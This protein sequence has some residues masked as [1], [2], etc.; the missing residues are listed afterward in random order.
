MDPFLIKIQRGDIRDARVRER[1]SLE[2]D[3]DVVVADSFRKHPRHH[4]AKFQNSS[5]LFYLC[6]LLFTGLFS[7]LYYLQIVRGAEYYGAAEINRIRPVSII[8]PRGVIFDS[9]G[10]RMAYNV[11]DFALYV[12]PADLPEGQEEEDAQFVEIG[13]IL[14]QDPY[15]LV[16]TFARVPRSS[17]ARFEV[18][19]GLSQEQAVRLESGINKWQGIGVLPIEERAYG[20]GEQAAHVLGYTGPISETEYQDLKAEGYFL[21]EHTG[22]TGV[23]K[24][25]QSEL[26][27]T[28]GVRYIEVDS[29]GREVALLGETAPIPGNNVRLNIDMELQ[30]VAY[31]A[32]KTAVEDFESPGGSVIVMDPQSGA[33]RAYVNYPGY[34]NQAFINGIGSE[35]YQ[36]LLDDPRH[37][38]LDRAIQGEYPSGSTFKM[39]VAAAGLEEGVIT[40]TS[41]VLST[42]GL[43]VGIY[44]YPDWKYGGHG[45]TNVIKGLAESV[46]TFFYVLGGGWDG[47]G[48]LGVDR[49]V[50]YGRQF[51]LA[52][53]TGIDLPSE[54]AG[55]LPSRQWKLETKGERWYLGDT[56]HVSIGQGDILVTPVQVANMTAAVANRGTLYAPRLAKEFIMP[57]GTVRTLEPMVLRERVAAAS[58]IDTVREGLRA[59]VTRGSAL[60]L[61]TISVPLAG[62][63]G[64]AQYSSTGKPHAWFTGFGPY[65]NPEIV[66][67]VLVE[68]GEE[69]TRAATP[70]AKKIFEWYFGNKNPNAKAQMPNE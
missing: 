13:E 5:V 6:A 45:Q 51:G 36:A 63:T 46:N 38:L 30:R 19:R 47:E 22:K 49:I 68:K 67:T 62:K 29:K 27:G 28:A 32:L 9:N 41:S 21:P 70:V 26:R 44:S 54:R 7:K 37:P 53:K 40:P 48:G 25:Y 23:E 8:P 15:D 59:A 52:E 58:A 1:G 20:A 50:R 24:I 69:S 61:S 65:D 55:F 12:T 10:E 31:E 66:V 18:A 4:W 56:Y 33:V 2:V 14:G 34:D 60:S 35:A 17:V 11:P 39:V 3:G 16:K 43:R 57:N 64:T 42:G